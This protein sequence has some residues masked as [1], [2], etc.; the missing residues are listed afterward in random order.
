MMPSP[1]KRRAYETLEAR[2]GRLKRMLMDRFREHTEYQAMIDNLSAV[3]PGADDPETL[4]RYIRDRVAKK[5][6]L[7]AQDGSGPPDWATAAVKWDVYVRNKERHPDPPPRDDLDITLED[8]RPE[9]RF[10]YPDNPAYSITLS[11]ESL[12]FSFE[13]E[14]YDESGPSWPVFES[15]V[16]LAFLTDEGLSEAQ[17]TKVKRLA[18]GLVDRAVKEMQSAL[19]ARA[20]AEA[21]RQTQ[22]YETDKKIAAALVAFLL[23]GTP[24]LPSGCSGDDSRDTVRERITKVIGIK[25]PLK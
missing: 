3:V 9:P 11:P 23:L 13:I 22:S 18:R 14:E 4:D 19:L 21:D 15:E 6:R 25:L 20:Q 5:L 10:R 16:D 12:R 8:A 2:K 24:L 1:S 17:F 7:N